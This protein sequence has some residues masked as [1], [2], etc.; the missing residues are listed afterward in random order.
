[1]WPTKKAQKA[2]AKQQKCAKSWNPMAAWGKKQK[3]IASAVIALCIIGLAVGLGVGVSKA[4][5]GGVNTMH[6][7]TKPI[8]TD[9]GK[10]N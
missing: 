6:G 9:E 1:M 5:G 7:T 2:K 8:G 4:V 3:M 10:R